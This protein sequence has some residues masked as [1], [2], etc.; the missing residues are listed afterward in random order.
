MKHEGDS[1]VINMD[2]DM[3]RLQLKTNRAQILTPVIASESEEIELPKVMIQGAVKNRAFVRELELN[4]ASYYE[5]ESNLPYAIVKPQGRLNYTFA[6]PFEP[7][8][9]E[10]GLVI[11][12][13]L[14]GCGD[15]INLVRTNVFEALTIDVIAE[16]VYRVRPALAYIRPEV[17]EIKRRQEIGNAYLD[18]P[19]GKNEIFPFFGN[20]PVEL[21]KIDNMIRTISTNKDITVHRIFMVGYASPESSLRFNTE[22]S[23]ARSESM[24]KYFMNN[25]SIPSYMFE[26]RTGGE[27]W[28][29][30]RALLEDFPISQAHKNEIF[31]IMNTVHDLDAR[32]RAISK[33][34]GGR[35]Y[36]LI[37]DQ[38]YP[39]LRRVVCEIHYTVRDFSLE[40][41]KENMKF[42]PQLL[43]L[44]EMFIVANT[45]EPGSPEFI[46]VF[47][48]AR[49]E[50]PLDPVANLNGGAAALAKGNL[51]DAERFLKV[52]DTTTPEYAN[53]MGVF[54]LLRG[55]YRE[56]ER[57]LKRAESMGVPEAAANL[58]EL[59]RK[60]SNVNNRR[61]AGVDEY[62]DN[63]PS[64]INPSIRR[65]VQ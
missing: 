25:S 24:M 41:A 12:E 27:D 29:G 35:P 32:E 60:V 61:E 4:D 57:L 19:R 23:R 16:P 14:C 22:L 3:S 2:I 9:S 45:Y 40:E 50:F 56:A 20:N 47:E 46:R 63:P 15:Y 26:T 43:S 5:F 55:D 7:W 28:D 38:I 42:A 17:E 53:N 36:K 33:V 13:D 44:N 52:S 64:T 58:R 49:E 11:E 59:S 18:F 21:A 37:Y 51:R 54:M 8:M 48:I 65:R 10:A 39:Q 1:L 6:V 31:Y 30:F 62:S 34:G